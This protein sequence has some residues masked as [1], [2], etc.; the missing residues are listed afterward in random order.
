MKKEMIGV[1]IIIPCYNGEKY[2]IPCLQ[3][4]EK[5]VQN[6]LCE[7]ILVDDK[8]TDQTKK[9]IQK[10]MKSSKMSI[11]L[12]ENS[13]NKGAGFSRNQALLKAKYSYISFIDADDYLDEH[14]YKEMLSII[15]KE[16]AD[17]AICDFQFVYEDDTPDLLSSAC[18]GKVSKYNFINHGLAASPCN[19]IIKKEYL[20]QYPFAE[21]I[22]N[23]DVATILAILANC[24]TVSY[25]NK[26]KYHYVQ[27]NTSTQ[28]APLSLKRLDI[29]VSL[30]LLK[31]RIKNNRNY[32]KFM[33][34]ILFH[35]VISLF[36]FV[37]IKE[38]NFFVRAKFLKQ[39]YKKTKEYALRRNPLYWR[40]LEVNNKKSR[41][42]YK[43]LMKLNC[44]GFSYTTS[45]IMSMY[46]FYKKFRG[47]RS[48]IPKTITLEDLVNLAKKQQ[49]KKAL[50]TVSVAIPNYNYSAFLYQRLYSILAQTYKIEEVIILDDC[51]TDTSREKINEVVEALKPFIR[52]RKEYNKKNS[53]SV[54]KQWKKSIE[55]ASSSYVWIAEADDYCEKNFLKSLMSFIEKD[56]E[57]T[58]AY[59]DTAY[60]N[61]EGVKILKTIKPE[62]DILKTGHWDQ[63]FVS[64][65]SS[66]IKNYAYLNCTIANVSSVLIKKG[67]YKECFKSLQTYKQAGDYLFYV[68]VM[69]KGKIAYFN[70]PL[71]YYRMHGSNV[72]STT[73]K[74]LHLEEIKRV[75][76]YIEETYGLDK[77]QKKEIEKRYKFLERVWNLDEDK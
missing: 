30:D 7:I 62:I 35:Q 51:S 6:I 75:H 13:V 2:I 43:L 26:T 27:R 76:Q 73:K 1:S 77:K 70:K 58:L 11:Q 44:N 21:G 3:S 31:E 19:K 42:Y 23:E 63:S 67:D 24:K 65:G 16:N 18:E 28:N 15:K 49:N 29:F 41:F 8:S 68:Y 61:K 60:I 12:L 55:L 37:P 45:F 47:T 20:L 48:V 46:L 50:E 22:M 69:S 4:I 71:N 14:F 33:Q 54:F 40:F 52:I 36:L 57:I 17:V 56:K 64:D 39:F 9:V 53:G 10:F 25:T 72:T 66:E 32:E 5:Q 59:T 74:K 34:A 38:K